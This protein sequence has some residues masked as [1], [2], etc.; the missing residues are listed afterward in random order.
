MTMM[1]ACVGRVFAI[2]LATA[3]LAILGFNGALLRAAGDAYWP[4][5]RWRTSSPEA[6]GLDSAILAD[7]FDYVRAHRTRIHSLSIVRNG[8]LVLDATFFPFQPNQLHDVASVT[9]SITTTL[10]GVAIGDGKLRGGNQ[11]M[12]A[13]F[14]RRAVQNRDVRKERLTVEHLL[15]MS[16]GLD[17]LYSGG[18]STLRDMRRSSDWIQFMLDRPMVADPGTK[19]EYCSSGMHLLSGIVS[20]ATAMSAFEYGRHRLFRPLGILDAGWPADP[21]GISHGWGDLRLKPLD[22]ARIGYLW[23]KEGQWK[24]QQ[25]IPRSWMTSAIQPRAR[26]LGEEYGYG[27]WLN[28]SRDPFVFEANGRGGQRITVLPSKHL[29]L[30]ITGGAF[31]PGE[32]GAFILKAIRSDA[33]LP[34]NPTATRRLKAAISAARRPPAAVGETFLPATAQRISGKRYVLDPN[35]VGWR[36][37]TLDFTKRGKPTVSLEFTDREVETR[38]MGLDGIPRLS[39]RGRFGLPVAIH[40]SWSGPSTFVLDYDEVANINAFVC[41]FTFEGDVA[42]I[43][44]KERSGELDIR[45]RGSA[46]GSGSSAE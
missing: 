7:A 43:D 11:P 34:E 17:C 45:I 29:V 23:L 30:A 22:M 12:L 18:E 36:A 39:A 46:S 31:E 20:E 33:S 41:R 19:G 4:G 6:Q 13:V 21:N 37:V 2:V 3:G 26:V 24:G 35:S 28:R 8:Y 5:D 42:W 14:P 38:V 27:L 1:S 10:I 9:K 32:I 15:T 25:I 16:S 40:G 44:L